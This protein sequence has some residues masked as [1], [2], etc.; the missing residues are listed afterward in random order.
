MGSIMHLIG[1]GNGGYPEGYLQSV[2]LDGSRRRI[3]PARGDISESRKGSRVPSDSD[4]R[5]PTVVMTVS[6]IGLDGSL[7]RPNCVGR[8]GGVG[9]IKVDCGVELAKDCGSLR[10]KRH[11]PHFEHVDSVLIEQGRVLRRAG[12]SAERVECIPVDGDRRRGGEGDRHV[13]GEDN[14]DLGNKVAEG[15]GGP[16]CKGVEH[17][18]KRVGRTRSVCLDSS[19][20][21]FDIAGRFGHGS[22]ERGK[23]KELDEIPT[24]DTWQDGS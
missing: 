24:K 6:R 16:T 18:G 7:L 15:Q 12:K 4:M 8:R 13:S 9:V 17:R 20:G 10:G 23:R 22:S 14:V 11:D 3:D 19:S 2:V 5:P 21:K 1:D